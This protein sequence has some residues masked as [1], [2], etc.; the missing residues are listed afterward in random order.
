[1]IKGAKQQSVIRK[2]EWRKNQTQHHTSKSTWTCEQKGGNKGRGDDKW[3]KVAECHKKRRME[4]EPNTTLQN[5][6]CVD[7]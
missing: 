5:K 4:E 7:V 3:G 6:E 2:K 1:M